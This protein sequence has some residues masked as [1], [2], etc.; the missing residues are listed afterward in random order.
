[1]LTDMNALRRLLLGTGK[2]PEPLRTQLSADDVLVLEEGLAGSVTYRN[3]RA[4]GQRIGVGKQ[5]VSG[6]I[7]MTNTRLVVWAGRMKHIDVPR[8]HPLWNA[9]EVLAETPD[10]VRFTYDAGAT[11]TALSGQ[12]TVRLRTAQAARIA[13][14]HAGPGPAGS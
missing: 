12:V 9:I 6:A 2:L 7:A 5:A 10:R 13:Q 11:N 8:G 4:P 1:M 14:I 3:Y